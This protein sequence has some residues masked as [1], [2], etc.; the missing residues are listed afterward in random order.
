M[1]GPVQRSVVAALVPRLP[2]SPTVLDIGCGTGRLLE[3]IGK[4][5]HTSQLVGLDRSAGMVEEAQRLRPH[6][7]LELSTAEALPH[8]DGC[9]DAV[10]TTVSFHHWADKGAAVSEV[11]RVLR[12]RGLFALTDMSIDDLPRWPRRLWALPR[13]GLGDMP[14]L[15]ERHRLLESAGL[16][17]VEVVPTLHRRWITL[18][19][20]ERPS[21]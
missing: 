5:A 10:V 2:P 15:R 13:Q 18:T 20:A 9:F 4:A 1:F 21:L 8:P 6:L 11:F 7:R 16:R 17:V 3:R 14:P 19:L 12:P